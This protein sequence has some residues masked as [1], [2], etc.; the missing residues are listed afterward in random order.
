MINV[1][2]HFAPHSK[3]WLFVTSQLLTPENQEWVNNQMHEFTSQWKAHN[4]PLQA[5][6]GLYNRL[7]WVSVNAN[8]ENASGCSIDG[9]YRKIAEIEK[10]TQT[11]F[12]D[13]MWLLSK[14]GICLHAVN[15]AHQLTQLQNQKVLNLQI[16]SVAQV[17]NAFIPSNTCWA[18][19][20][21]YS[22]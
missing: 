14:N 9:L 21:I 13:K 19:H 8:T 7:L 2:S 1:P 16:N 5:T 20:K 4:I 6:F 10:A 12:T 22:K 18:K 3:L 15:D 11:N 17:S